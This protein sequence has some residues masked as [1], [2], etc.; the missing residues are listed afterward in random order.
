MEKM[1]IDFQHIENQDK[2]MKTWDPY[3]IWV[4]KWGRLLPLPLRHIQKRWFCHHTWGCSDICLIGTYFGPMCVQKW[5]I[6]YNSKKK[7]SMGQWWFKSWDVYA[8]YYQ[9]NQFEWWFTWLP[10]FRINQKACC[11]GISWGHW[12]QTVSEFNN[13]HA[14]KWWMYKLLCIYYILYYIHIIYIF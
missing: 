10:R 7:L 5:V 3:F 8:P 13:A 6:L 12:I 4:Q 14:V 11:S 9:T 1:N 2:N